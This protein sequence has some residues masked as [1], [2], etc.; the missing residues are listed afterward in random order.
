MSVNEEVLA[1]ANPLLV[2]NGKVV[3]SAAQKLGNIRSP[4]CFG[5]YRMLR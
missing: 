4:N 1:A 2:V 5:K 3:A